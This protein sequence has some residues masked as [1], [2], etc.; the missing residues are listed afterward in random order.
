MKTLAQ[1]VTDL[2]S[3]GAEARMYAWQA[4]DKRQRGAAEQVQAW[5][6]ISLAHEMAADALEELDKL[7]DEN[8]GD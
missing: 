6:D 1:R 7:P 3:E 2:R 5:L 4:L 8:G